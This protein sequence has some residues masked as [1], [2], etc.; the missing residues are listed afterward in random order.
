MSKELKTLPDD[1]LEL[2]DQTKTHEPCE[3]NLDWA[4]EHFKELLRTRLKERKVEEGSLRFSSMGQP[5]RKVWYKAHA[6]PEPMSPKNYFKFLYGDVIELLILFLAKEAGHTVE[7]TQ[8]ELEVEVS[9]A[10]LTR[11]LM[12]QSLMLNPHPPTASRNS[13]KTIF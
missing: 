4:A 3:E 10:T 9:K 12:E 6:E 13:K 7:R 11:S 2:F 5:D 1:I 8:E